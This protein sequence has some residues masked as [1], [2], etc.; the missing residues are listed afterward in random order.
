MSTGSGSAFQVDEITGSGNVAVNVTVPG[1]SEL[2]SLDSLYVV[3]PSNGSFGAEYISNLGA[4]DAAV[5][6][7]MNLIVFDRFVTN[8]QTILPGGS[9]IKS[10]RDFSSGSDVNVAAGA[11]EKFVNGPNGKITDETFDGGNYSSH[12]YV[13][14][15]TL[16]KGAVPL[17]TT[18][19]PEHVVAF[20]YPHGEGTVFYSTMPIDYYSQSNNAAI[21]P[22]EIITL[23]GN[24]Q[25]IA[26]FVGGT[27]ILTAHGIR[28][29]EELQV[30][31]LLPVGS[32]GVLPI[33]WIGATRVGPFDLQRNPGLYPVRIQA[34][35]LGSDLPRRDLLVSRQHRILV[36]SRIARRMFAKD[37]QL[38]AAT[39]LVGLPGISMDTTF[40]TLRY[41]HI[42][43]DRHEV[44]WAEDVPTESLFVGAEALKS[45]SHAAR[46]EVLTLFP[47]L[48]RGAPVPG[49]YPCPK[50]RHQRQLAL[51]HARNGRPLI[52]RPRLPADSLIGLCG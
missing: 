9:V 17:L 36:A 39:S 43:L 5:T 13:E 32:G 6:K 10:V 42:L 11:P 1:A 4:I 29:V 37:E 46:S 33:R 26:C 30:G 40:C 44:I 31:E 23:F 16:P 25:Q 38:V 15:S 47:E 51:R 22:N 41:Y 18:S 8:A 20:V 3:N 49:P 12:G 28:R 52:E 50:G 7:G 2:A 45:M 34:G 27:G 14:L 21:T 35:A 19:D 48:A 24:V